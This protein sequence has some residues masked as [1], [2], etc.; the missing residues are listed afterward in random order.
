M[1]PALTARQ[2]ARV[3]AHGRSREVRSGETIVEPNAQGIKFFVVV[4]GRLELLLL[5]ENKEEVIALSEPSF[6][7]GKLTRVPRAELERLM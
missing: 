1:F 2:Q 3:L 6:P 4:A 7:D 5:S